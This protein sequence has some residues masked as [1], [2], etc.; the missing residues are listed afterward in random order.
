MVTVDI[1]IRRGV[2]PDGKTS[3]PFLT[4]T[5]KLSTIIAAVQQI[6]GEDHGLDNITVIIYQREPK[7]E[8]F[9]LALGYSDRHVADEKLTKLK[10]KVTS[11]YFENK[12]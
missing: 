7:H 2:I 9:I 3:I 11:A 5:E 1:R 4:S 8:I 6:D 12:D 10:E